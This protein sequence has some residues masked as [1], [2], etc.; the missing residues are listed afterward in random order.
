MFG[1]D[2]SGV[3]KAAIWLAI[4]TA[5]S[6]LGYCVVDGIKDHGRQEVQ[7]EI[8]KEENDAAKR[9]EGAREKFRDRVGSD[10][11]D[12]VLKRGDF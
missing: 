5:V 11:T 1:L 3:A 7:A 6:T 12:G 9:M 8:T 2:I 10:G 4:I